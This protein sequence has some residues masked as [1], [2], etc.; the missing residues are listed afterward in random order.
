VAV[1]S[2]DA[3]G[4][5][6]HQ[7]VVEAGQTVQSVD[8]GNEPYVRGTGGDD[9]VEFATGANHV[10]TLN[11]EEYV[12]DAS[13]VPVINIDGLGG[14]DSIRIYGTPG[15]ETASLEVLSVDLLG[16]GYEV[17]ANDVEVVRVYAGGGTDEAF[18]TGSAGNE[19]FYGRQAYSYL[20]RPGL[21]SYVS[22]F[23]SVEADVRAGG[24]TSNDR[25][26]LYDSSGNDTFYGDPD[27]SRME[28]ESGVVNKA[29]GFDIV[30]AYAGGG[31]HDEAR[32]TGSDADDRFYSYETHGHLSGPGF[33]NYAS[34]F[35]YVEADVTTGGATSRD[36]AWLFDSA[37]DDTFYAGPTAARLDR[38]SDGTDEAV[39]LGFDITRAYAGGGADHD[40]AYLTGSAGDDRFYSY[41]TYSY[42][43]DAAGTAFY[44]FVRDFDYVEVDALGET[45]EDRAYIDDTSGDDTFRADPA[46]ATLDY[47]T[48]GTDNVRVS[49]FEVVKAY[50]RGGGN[51]EA[52]LTGSADDDRLYGYQEYTYLQGT[53]FYNYVELFDYVEADGAGHTGG[54]RADLYDS[55]LGASDTFT[56]HSTAGQLGRMDYAGGN[57]TEALNF[58]FGYARAPVDYSDTDTANLHSGTLWSEIGDWEVVNNLGPGAPGSTAPDLEFAGWIAALQ[59][60]EAGS[61]SDGEEVDLANL[62]YVF[63]LLGG[64]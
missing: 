37:G 64:P 38:G 63:K 34:G 52:Y 43:K 56:G 11:G 24:N 30:K 16:P 44:N 9:T 40:E 27:S 48:T 35:D 39:A 58:E 36:R 33:Y 31:D 45:A 29:A 46:V 4:P 42:L 3:G 49:D 41:D 8:F 53:G 19:K 51:D 50:A 55:K 7:V 62:D 32:L 21:L 59:D 6:P 57:A 1:F 26:Y 18:L 17:H 47:G 2:R 61:S 5:G 23:D 28:L 13:V 14:D 60:A 25:A 22:G 54:D 15:N 10:V 20:S 12:Y